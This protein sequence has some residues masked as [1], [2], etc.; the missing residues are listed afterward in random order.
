MS[1]SNRINHHILHPRPA[2]VYLSK[3]PEVTDEN[4][5]PTQIFIGKENTT[6]DH[7]RHFS[8]NIRV[9][10][11]EISNIL[12]NTKGVLHQKQSIVKPMKK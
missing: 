1:Q 4:R 7:S 12:P 3:Q 9:F 6:F 11:R 2:S 5:K 10:G 8:S